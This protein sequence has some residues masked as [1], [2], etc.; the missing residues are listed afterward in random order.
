MFRIPH[1]VHILDLMSYELNEEQRSIQDL[2]RRVAREKVAARADEIDRTAEYPHDMFELLKELGLFAL[3]FP[4]EYGGI[5]ST[6]AACIAVEELGRVCYNTGYLLVVQWT[7]FGAILAGGT[8]EQK[9]RLLPGLASGALRGSLSLTEP[10]S[11]SDVSGIKTTARRTAE[12]YVLNGA[13]IWATNSDIADFILVAAKTQDERGEPLGIN[14]FIVDKGTPGLSVGRKEDKMGARGVP[15]CPLFFDNALVPANNRLGP[16]G[17]QGF[18][19]AME[20]LN[21]S[22]PI[23]A[24]RAVGIA[25]G[26]IDHTARYIQERRAFGQAI[27]DFQGVRWMMADMVMQTEA[28]RQLVYRTAAMVDAGASG[29]ELAP[30][31]AMAK[32]FASDV[33]MKVATDAVQLF[34]AAGVSAEYPINRYFRDAKVVQIIEG[35]NQ[36][37]RNIIAGSVLG[38]AGR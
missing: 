2:V 11:G 10:Q 31:A 33:A 16:E 17:G 18:K 35:T 3:P 1:Y 28:A 14:L 32:C 26:A 20:A 19:V 4:A 30:M 8:E 34:G 29:K 36:I 13:K 21:T 5:G 12:G 9:Q 27:S 6:L 22:R 7:P 15:S 25:Q 23:V 38:K 37:Q 24:A